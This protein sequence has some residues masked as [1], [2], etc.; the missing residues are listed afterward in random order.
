MVCSTYVLAVRREQ[1]KSSMDFFKC[2]RTGS[3]PL[4]L[5]AVIEQQEDFQLCVLACSCFGFTP[6]F[7]E[8][9]YYCG[10]ARSSDYTTQ[11]YY[12]QVNTGVF[13]FLLDRVEDVYIRVLS[14]LV[15]ILNPSHF[16][17]SISNKL[18]TT[19]RAS[20][21]PFQSLTQHHT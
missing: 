15:S 3:L 6:R 17:F 7:H 21:F 19:I 14:V 9:V 13:Y 4:H 5:R 2:C 8:A 10:L 12:F 16:V 18:Y 1:E 11:K 20:L